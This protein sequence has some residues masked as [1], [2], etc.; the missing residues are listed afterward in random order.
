MTPLEELLETLDEWSTPEG[1]PMWIQAYGRAGDGGSLVVDEV[2]ERMLGW[3]AP[4]SCWAVGVVAGGWAYP[5]TGNGAR[6]RRGCAGSRRV[7]TRCLVG[8][9]GEVVSR[10]HDADGT[11]VDEPPST[12]R[13]ID[14]LRRCV[15]LTTPPPDRPSSEL[16]ALVWMAEVVAAAEG[17]NRRSVAS[18]RDHRSRPGGATVVGLTWEEVARL[19]PAVLALVTDG[20]QVP[21]EH[22]DAVLRS[23]GRAWSWG[24][25]REL[26]AGGG[27]PAGIVPSALAAWMDDGMFSRW[28]LDA[29]APLSD[30]F[31][32]TRAALPAAVGDQLGSCL[33]AAGMA[34]W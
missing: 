22:M 15:G 34:R 1:G 28:M 17:A 26:A 33:A 19:H 10:L 9:D 16:L 8:R 18:T 23:A 27:W 11:V 20:H 31:A 21:L 32:L 25:L 24:H 30:V 14:A 7:Q 5:L 13:T 12:G 6:P 29:S 4:P 3:V 2:M